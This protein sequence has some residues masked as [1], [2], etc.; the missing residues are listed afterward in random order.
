MSL[1]DVVFGHV[2]IAHDDDRRTLFSI[3]NGKEF[4]GFHA[5]TLKWF[6][7]KKDA[8]VAKHYHEYDEIFCVVSGEDIFELVDVDSMEKETYFLKRGDILLVAKRVAHRCHV[9]KDSIVIA[10]NEKPYISAKQN[11]I[12]FDKFD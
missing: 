2:N 1:K 10:A 6:E 11:D 5:A 8:V 9:K 3:F 12:L 4:H 7:F